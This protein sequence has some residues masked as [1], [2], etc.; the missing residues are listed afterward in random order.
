MLF[1]FNFSLWLWSRGPRIVL[2]IL[3]SLVLLQLGLDVGD[4]GPRMI[5]FAA[6]VS[7][8]WRAKATTYMHGMHLTIQLGSG[9]RPCAQ[10]QRIHAP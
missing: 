2:P 5:A 3:L 10:I 9:L 1:R 6:C 4:E 7:W 8:G